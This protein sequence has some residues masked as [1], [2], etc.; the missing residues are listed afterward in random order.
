MSGLALDRVLA[1]GT[2]VSNEN[3]VEPFKIS[4]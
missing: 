1:A 3:N 4:R 2:D